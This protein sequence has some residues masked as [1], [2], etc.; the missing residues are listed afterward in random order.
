MR[1]ITAI[2]IFLLTSAGVTQ[3]QG[4][5]L[6]GVF[7]DKAGEAPVKGA[8]V[9]LT[10]PQDSTFKFNAY[11]DK[12]GAFEIKGLSP[13]LVLLTVTS[14]GYSEF[15]KAF[16]LEPAS[17]NMG[18][19]FMTK[20]ATD[21]KA[22]TIKGQVPPAQQKGDTTAY[23]AAAFKTNPDASG[24]DLVRKMPGITVE[25][26]TVKAHGEEVRKVLLDGKEYFGEDA[27]LA[28]RNLPAEVIN[29]IE[30]F[31]R[32][33]DQAQFTGFDDGNSSK[34]INI[35]TNGSVRASQFGKIYAGYGT[36]ERYMAGGNVNFF[37]GDRRIAIIGM[38]NN[39]N[40]Q[41]FS[42]QDILGVMGGGG[43]GFGGGGGGR[44]GGRGG[45][46]GNWGG[47]AGGFGGNGGGNFMVGNS[48]GNNKT[49][50]FG[51]NFSDNWGKKLQVTGSYFF[52]NSINEN[53][54]KT[55]RQTILSA[56]TSTYYA[57]D[58]QSGSKNYNHRVNMRL[59]YKIDS[60]NSLI[61]TPNISFQDNNSTTLTEGSLGY[62]P[63]KPYTLTYNRREA[64]S[65]GFNFNN[66]ILY[67]HA[68]AKRGRTISLGV[69]TAVNKR[70][71]ETYQQV[72]TTNVTN[73]V[74]GYSDSSNRVTLPQSDGF[75]LSANLSYTEPLGKQGQLQFNYNPSYS[76]S[77]SDQKAFLYDAAEQKYVV[78]DSTLSNVYSN[79]YATQNG[80]VTYRYGNR[81]KMLSLGMNYQYSELSGDQSFPSET[82]IRKNFSNVLPNAMLRWKFD[83]RNS[84]RVFY[85]AGVNQPSVTQL[86]GVYNVT[87]PL[88][89]SVGNPDLDQQY[90]HTLSTRYSYTNTTKGTS[91][92]ANIFFQGTQ[93][94]VANA[95]YVVR[96]ADSLIVSSDTLKRGSQLSKP[97][98]LDGYWSL[99]AFLNYGVPL[100]FIKTNLNLNGGVTYA[101]TPGVINNVNSITDNY[102][103]N[104]GAVLSSNISEYV[105]YTLSY[106]AN[107]NVVKNSVQ[108]SQN[109][110]YFSH[111]AGVRLNLLSKNGWFLSND[112]NNQFYSGLADG[113]NQSYWLWN[114]GAGKKFLKD[115]KGELKLS[116]FDLLNQNR[117]ISRTV[118][119]NVIEDVSTMV[120]RQYF[121]LTF[122]YTLRNFGKSS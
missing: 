100:K 116:V 106:S 86:Q 91:F 56:D 19:Q 43:G 97:V 36:D 15:S 32:L 12:D 77:E 50:S 48:S 57:E 105:D 64:E 61:I 1:Q 99:R 14:I 7:K 83:D 11:T 96:G 76:K 82:K 118:D 67:R 3:A 112:L 81:D 47:G 46:G 39:V 26:G 18:V 122:T 42:S 119:G 31:D 109:Y 79:I 113:F 41:N 101:H 20:G 80:G 22:V 103:Y 90:S 78:F 59:E 27:T 24:E 70:D 92:F 72:Y 29:K 68:F 34:T 2:I 66:N 9:R 107:Y 63:A 87:N 5:V 30:V 89:W 75:Q 53:L 21:L 45:G 17:A 52:N 55:N 95:T 94:Y 84:V 115:R 62:L 73:N 85:R 58:Q 114:A 13:Q 8:T 28:L 120:L 104:A 69:T 4:L 10:S 54:T 25:N 44:G 6:K 35:V 108:P 74:A 38:A 23:N 93:D 60:S 88:F 49:N 111:T 102:N 117:A 37:K 40:Q 121:M 33:S 98:N 51:I 16:M 65:N 110:N 71:G